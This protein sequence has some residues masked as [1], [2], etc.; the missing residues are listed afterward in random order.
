[1]QGRR[2]NAFLDGLDA[3]DGFGQAAGAHEV[4]GRGLGG[5]HRRC[6]F[7]AA[8]HGL[9]RQRFGLVAERRG[10]AVRVDIANVGRL[11]AGLLERQLHAAGSAFAVRAG[12]GNVVCI[13]G[14][15]VTGEYGVDFCAAGECMLLGLDQESAAA[16][17]DNEA[18][19]VKVER[20][21]RLLGVVVSAGKR[22]GLRQTGNH[23]RAQNALAADCQNR[24]C[25]AGAEQHR[26]GH[27]G[28]AACRACR[29]ERQTRAV[30]A[31]CN[32]DLGSSDVADGHRHKARADA[33]ACVERSLRLCNGG[34]AVHCSAHDDADTVAFALDGQLT[35]LE[36]LLGRNKGKLHERVHRAGQRFRHVGSGIEVLQLCRNLH[37]QLGCIKAGNFSYTALSLHQCGPVCVHTNTD[38]RNSAH[39]GDDQF[40]F[41]HACS[42]TY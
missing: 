33:L 10:R 1:M 24:V 8:E 18:V 11:H 20:A 3:G 4:A 13:R 34:N 5:A 30:N 28:I 29:V 27:D 25:L 37:G 7:A 2:K 22:L 32:R 31:V 9:D 23:D 41:F 40:L 12:R 35:V 16:F 6:A 42:P 19:A 38:R 39:T 15:R 21:A 36:S 14:V 26:C 17:T